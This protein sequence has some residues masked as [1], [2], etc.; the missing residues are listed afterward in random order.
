M[1]S[2]PDTHIFQVIKTIKANIMLKVIGF[3]N[4]K[5]NTPKKSK[6]LKNTPLKHPLNYTLLD[7]SILFLLNVK[8]FSGKSRVELC[9]I[10]AIKIV[11]YK[12]SG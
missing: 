10:K 12:K 6:T 5:T 11:T 8:K 4:K 2:V 7:L 3:V 1:L 9:D